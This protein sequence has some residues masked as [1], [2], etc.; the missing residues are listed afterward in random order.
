MEILVR[1]SHVFT[2]AALGA[3]GVLNK[4]AVY[5]QDDL[6]KEVDDFKVL[7]KKYPD[8][9]I[10][11][12]DDHVVLPGFIDAHQHGVGLSYIKRG[13]GYDFLENSLY[14]WAFSIDISPELNA[15]L[16]AL[17]HIR[18]G[19]TTLHHNDAGD[20]LAANAYQKASSYLNG[21]RDTGIR[22]AYSPGMND[23]NSL[24]CDDEAFYKTLPSEIKKLAYPL[25]FFN[26]KQARDKYFELFD[27]LYDEFNNGL[28]SVFLGPLLAHGATNEFLLAVKEKSEALGGLPI[29]IHTLQTPHQRAY[30]LKKYGKSLLMHFNDM[31]LVNE[32]L[33][34]GHAVYVDEADIAL[35]AERQSSTTHH[36]TCNFA[37]RNG[38][39]PVYYMLKAGVNVGLGMD[40]KTLND[41][42]DAIQELRLIY[43]LHRV[44]GFDLANTP[45]LTPYDVL[46]IGTCNA[47]KAVGMKDKIGCLK[48]GMKADIITF[49]TTEILRDPWIS[50]DI[51]IGEA[52]I[53]R[54][55]GRHVRNVLIDGQIVFNNGKFTT[56]D[57]ESLYEEVREAASRAKLTPEQ[58]AY[59]ETLKAIKPYLHE[60]Y[61][62]LVDFPFDPFYILNSK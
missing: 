16:V 26:K 5:V 38:I 39:S 42:L 11:G 29:H 8:A 46:A 48:P 31:G 50:P 12:G 6:I 22:V 18:N 17:Q 57:V 1:G 21:Y 40:D 19:S 51:D 49:D 60:W 56:I 35:L 20:V 27:K 25:V 32:N 47:A 23:V 10:I 45:A 53:Y 2:D 44:S 58:L 41:D 28:S 55:C 36:A 9:K 4:A 3:A 43:Y 15:K 30:G 33:V 52:F 62:N 34:L 24:A 37:M 54:A 14:D 61:K 13:A 7:K 59:A